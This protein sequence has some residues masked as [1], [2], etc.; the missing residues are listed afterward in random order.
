MTNPEERGRPPWL[1]DERIEIPQVQRD[2][3][4]FNRIKAAGG[5]CAPSD[6]WPPKSSVR[7]LRR[8]RW[9]ARWRRFKAACLQSSLFWIV[10]LLF[11]RYAAPEVC[12]LFGMDRGQAMDVG[13]GAALGIAAVLIAAGYRRRDR[14]DDE[15]AL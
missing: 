6:T 3:I 9:R 5:W 8:N 4:D 13:V 11:W 1:S 7:L 10:A 14:D 15:G 2:G 12:V